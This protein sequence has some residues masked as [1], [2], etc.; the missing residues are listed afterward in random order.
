MRLAVTEIPWYLIADK[1]F[2]LSNIIVMI[3]LNKSHKVAAGAVFD[4]SHQMLLQVLLF[5]LV[6]Y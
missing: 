5:S 2:R 1:N 4:L 3:D 6:K